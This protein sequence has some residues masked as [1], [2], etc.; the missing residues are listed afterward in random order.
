M[1]LF[2]CIK[3]VKYAKLFKIQGTGSGD[4]NVTFISFWED[5]PLEFVKFS[6]WHVSSFSCIWRKDDKAFGKN[7]V[8]FWR[9]IA[10]IVNLFFF[11]TYDNYDYNL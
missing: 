3:F 6:F 1:Y 5:G 4:V 7:T 10:Y 9:N 11:I 2:Y 8:L